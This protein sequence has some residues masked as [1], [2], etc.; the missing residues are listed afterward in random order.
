MEVTDK[1]HAQL[2]LR[3]LLNMRLG[4]LQSRSEC[5][6]AGTNLVL[7]TGFEARIKQPIT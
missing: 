6:G 2:Y 7:M 3:N 1:L 5:F 4:G